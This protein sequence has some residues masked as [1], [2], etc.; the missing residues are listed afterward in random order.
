MPEY[1][2]INL[3]SIGTG[4]EMKAISLADRFAR[5]F[6][7]GSPEE[8]DAFIWAVRGDIMK[9][10]DGDCFV[11]VLD[12]NELPGMWQAYPDGYQSYDEKRPFVAQYPYN[13]GDRVRY[14][15]SSPDMSSITGNLRALSDKVKGAKDTFVHDLNMD[16]AKKFLDDTSNGQ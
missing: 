16:P 8:V 9:L 3:S 11:Y 14:L 6:H 2:R 12:G 4:V 5:A 1:T 10:N 13:K 15:T 7:I